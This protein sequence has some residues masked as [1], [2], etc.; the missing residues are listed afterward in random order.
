MRNDFQHE[1]EGTALR[2]LRNNV[3]INRI[4]DIF[5]TIYADVTAF[6]ELPGRN[7]PVTE[8]TEP[9][10]FELYRTAAERLGVSAEVPV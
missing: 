9:A 7:F 2:A 5:H 10:L 1:K 6:A 4:L 3:L 8:K